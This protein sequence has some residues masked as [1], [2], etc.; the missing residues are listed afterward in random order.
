M[1]TEIQM[2]FAYMAFAAGD[3]KS[4]EAA[5]SHFDMM[6]GQTKLAMRAWLKGLGVDADTMAVHSSVHLPIGTCQEVWT[7]VSERFSSKS[8]A[9]QF[10]T[11]TLWRMD[12]LELCNHGMV[13]CMCDVCRPD[14]LCCHPGCEVMLYFNLRGK[15]VSHWL[16]AVKLIRLSKWW[17][18][19]AQSVRSLAAMYN[20]VSIT[21][22]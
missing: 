4:V 1:K 15:P 12:D 7:L 22:V 19:A 14:K 10:F 21:K 8:K 2:L 3:F 11:S 16:Y 9:I 6:H 20:P 18:F 5:L 17:M 13:Q